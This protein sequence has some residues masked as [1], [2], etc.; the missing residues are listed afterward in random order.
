[1]YMLRA[2]IRVYQVLISPF[3]GNICIFYPSCSNYAIKAL[4]VH[5]TIK[6]GWLI[7]K[8][9]LRCHSWNECSI[10]PVPSKENE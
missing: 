6:G 9:L 8:R 4:R 3:L 5:G 2:I 10:D 1:M 7:A